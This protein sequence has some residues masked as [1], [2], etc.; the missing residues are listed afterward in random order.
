MELWLEDQVVGPEENH[1]ARTSRTAHNGVDVCA[2]FDSVEDDDVVAVR[3]GRKS[4]GR[5]T[6]TRKSK[7][8]DEVVAAISRP[9]ALLLEQKKD[10]W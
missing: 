4:R 2:P 8:L 3:S 7:C 1:S 10:G 9:C 5:S 6:H